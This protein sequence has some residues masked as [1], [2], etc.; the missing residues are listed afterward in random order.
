[1][2]SHFDGQAPSVQ[3]LA[4]TVGDAVVVALVFGT[5]RAP[6]VVKN[7]GEFEVP[8]R[9]ATGT[10]SARRAELLT[11]L[12]PLQKLPSVEALSCRLVVNRAAHDGHLRQLVPTAR[13]RCRRPAGRAIEV[14]DR[15][16]LVARG[17]QSGHQHGSSR[18]RWGSGMVRVTTIPKTYQSAPRLIR[19]ADLLIRSQT[20]YPTE[21]WAREG[22]ALYVLGFPPS[23]TTRSDRLRLVPTRFRPSSWHQSGTNSSGSECSARVPLL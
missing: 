8:W 13:S 4:V 18:V 21:L 7:P 23:T 3:D 20:L 1:M 11:L 14:R 5:D 22:K 2:K 16:A 12:S 6:F 19:T 9:E 15:G 17:H 10:R